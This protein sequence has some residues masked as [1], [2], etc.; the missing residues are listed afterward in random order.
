M[1]KSE[2]LAHYTGSE[3]FY[4]YSEHLVVTDGVRYLI[5]N[6]CAWL[7]DIIA[8]VR[9]LLAFETEDFEAWTLTV[10]LEAHTAKV[11]ATDGDK[12]DG[13][14]TLYGQD[15]EYTDCPVKE[16]KL[17]VSRQGNRKTVM[18]NTEY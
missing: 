15:I 14:V 4:R 16:L 13:P 1:I 17:Y 12:G 2:E 5:D 3:H 9:G 10:D 8:S 18:L 7:I 6:G 11:I